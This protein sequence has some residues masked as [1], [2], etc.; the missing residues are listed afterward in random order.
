GR[1][2]TLLGPD[3]L[4][5][6]TL[7]RLDDASARCPAGHRHGGVVRVASPV[8]PARTTVRAALAAAAHATD[9]P[10]A[11]TL[12]AG[13]GTGPDSTATD[14]TGHGTAAHSTDPHG[15]GAP[16]TNPP[17]TEPRAG[18]RHWLGD[19]LGERVDP[20]LDRQLAGL[21]PVDRRL[22][23]LAV[24]VA[25]GPAALVVDRLTDGLDAEGRRALLA[26]L[27]CLAADRRAVLVDD[28]D[29]VAALAVADDAVRVGVPGVLERVELDYPRGV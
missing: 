7:A 8:P 22:V 14:S 24:A 21:G 18:A 23:A 5:R 29:P 19:A 6:A 15:N 28:S 10:R 17:T 13:H 26:L 12:S 16:T 11:S 20:L 27:R 3:A 9:E 25:Q 2:L 4:R 1:V